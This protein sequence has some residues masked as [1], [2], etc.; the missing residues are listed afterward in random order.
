[1]TE[2]NLKDVVSNSDNSREPT[3]NLQGLGYGIVEP[4]EGSGKPS[5]FALA[6]GTPDDKRRYCKLVE[7]YEEGLTDLAQS[8]D[9]QGQLQNCRVR[10]VSGGQYALTFGGRRCLAVL[11]LHAKKGKAATVMATVSK[12]DDKVAVIESAA[13]NIHLPPS[14]IDQRRLFKRLQDQGMTNKEI[15]RC[16]P[17]GKSGEQNIRHRVRLLELSPEDQLKVHHGKLSQDAALKLLK[18]KKEVESEAAPDE[19]PVDEPKVEETH[20]EGEPQPA[21]RPTEG[22]P[23]VGGKPKRKNPEQHEESKG[24]PQDELQAALG[25]FVSRLT[26]IDIESLSPPDPDELLKLTEEARRLLDAVE[27]KASNRTLALVG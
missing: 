14:Y 26:A 15:A 11:Y 25:D 19:T 1:M 13:E 6:L 7:Q 8:I 20:S 22:K 12:A 17:M 24:A 3:K 5:L 27:E 4:V 16:I 18:K 9:Q 21:P 2:I 10:R 23:E